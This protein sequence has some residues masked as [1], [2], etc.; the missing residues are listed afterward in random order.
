MKMC[1]R[2][3]IQL[4]VVAVLVGLGGCAHTD[5]TPVAEGET[6][7]PA[8]EEVVRVPTEETRPD[9]VPPGLLKVEAGEA[10]PVGDA[11]DPE[12]PS[13]VD[14]DVMAITDTYR[15]GPTDVLGFRSFDDASL[16]TDNLQVRH[17][18]YVSLPWVPDLKVAGLTRAEATEVVQTAYQEL[19]YEAEVSV[20]ILQANS[21]TYQVIGDVNRPAEYPYIKPITLLDAI[22]TAGSLRV[23]Q[24]GGDSFVGGQ[25]QLVKAFIIRGEGEERAAMEFDLRGMEEGGN[26]ETQTLV[27]PGD[28]VYIPEGLNLVYLLGEVGRPGVQPLQEGMTLLQLLASANGFRESSARLKQVVLIREVNETETEVQLFNVKEMLKTGGDVLVQPGDI[29]YVPRK[30]LVNL[31]EFISRSTGLV[32]PIMGVTSQA[33]GLYSQVWNAFYTEERIDLLYNSDNSSQLQT[34]LQLLDALRQVGSAAD[35]LGNASQLGG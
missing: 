5:S 30:R 4:L 6:G 16:N 2:T 10:A 21:R 35:V 15:I 13:Q 29:V 3:T 25:G 17:D 31:G 12:A 9:N 33:L 14:T 18:G 27:L 22:V 8:V 23:N 19:Y 11:A 20:Q 7:A 28:T 1:R 34:N 32:S 24:R 26:H